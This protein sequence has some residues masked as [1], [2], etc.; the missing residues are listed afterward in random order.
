[1][2][3]IAVLISSFVY[4]GYAP[5][6]PG[7]AGS[8]A[9]LL[10]YALVRWYGSVALEAAVIIAVALVGTWA[11]SVTERALGRTDPGQV[12]I[13]EVLGMLMTLAFLP[14]DWT[15]VLLAFFVFRALDIIKPFPAG[16]A[17]NL[18]GGLG[19]MADDAIAGVYGNILMRLALLVLP[20]WL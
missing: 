16:A 3:R 20:G 18:H 11:A 12:V 17:E 14:L 7:T 9:A 6:A 13:D 10:L 5:I 2:K 19:I 15:G 4:S 1:M 8:A